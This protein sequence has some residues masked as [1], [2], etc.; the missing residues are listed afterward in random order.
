MFET[1]DDYKFAY[2]DELSI[3]VNDGDGKVTIEEVTEGN[4]LLRIIVELKCVQRPIY[5]FNEANKT[6]YKGSNTD[7]TFVIKN[8]NGDDTDTF[9]QFSKFSIEKNGVLIE[10]TEDDYVLEE[11]S[12]KIHGIIF[13]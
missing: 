11:G 5:Q 13:P 6:Y 3:I 2:E 7:L 8:K 1:K 10:L 4:M 9:K 12:V